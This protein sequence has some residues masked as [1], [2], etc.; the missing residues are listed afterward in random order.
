MN[1]TIAFSLLV[2]ALLAGCSGKSTNATD[3]GAQLPPVAASQGCQPL[4]ASGDA[5]VDCLLPYPSDFFRVADATLPS[6]FRLDTSNAGPVTKKPL[7]TD[8]NLYFHID[9][10]SEIPSIVTMFPEAVSKTGFVGLLDDPSL[11]TQPS[12]NVLF[13]EAATG[14]LIP[15]FVDLDPHASDP[16]RQAIVIHALVPLTPGGRYVIAVHGVKHPDGSL[17]STPL[18]F[19]RLRDGTGSEDSV[20]APLQKHFTNDVLPVAVKAGIAQSDLQM[21]WD[22]TVGSDERRNG[23]MLQVRKLVLQWLQSNTPTVSIDSVTTINLPSD[24]WMQIEGTVHGA[25]LYLQNPNPEAQLFRDGNGVVA[26]NGTTDFPFTV[27]VPASVRDNGTPGM[28]MAYGHGFFGSREEITYDSTRKVAQDLGAVMFAIDWWGMDLA[29]GS[30]LAGNLVDH[31]AKTLDFADRVHQ[32]MAN[33][34][35][36]TS[37]IRGQLC[38]EPQ[39]QFPLTDGG[40]SGTCIIDDSQVVYFGISQGH[41]LGGTMTALNPDFHKIILQ[42]GGV[43]FT[44]MM[45]RAKP[46]GDDFLPFLDLSMPDP[47]EQQKYMAM[48]Q[49]QFD[50]FDPATYAPFVVHAPFPETPSDRRVMLQNG[51]G[52]DEVPNLGTFLDYRMLQVPLVTPAPAAPFGVQTVAAPY[53][54][55]AASLYD[56]DIDL[57]AQY[58]EAVNA[59]NE[60]N[61]HGTLRGVDAALQQMKKFYA[62]GTVDEF[63]DGGPCLEPCPAAPDSGL[64]RPNE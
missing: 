42:M 3:A 30:E 21:A 52:D 35:V 50:R 12:S 47:L 10:A 60:N 63:C 6:G 41:I 51:L 29:D 11:S 64:C 1:R 37:A 58:A 9:G 13:I 57:Q 56:F 19:A 48:M 61:V 4:L 16:T 5:G 20:L 24:T 38:A 33:W 53:A 18:G 49:P 28:A 22:F 31:P 25:P 23:D 27:Q 26:Q 39:L 46:F 40:A 8:V 55:S 44:H 32:G 62:D 14:N 17:V 43:G 36:M 2:A 7:N 34:I 59:V 45:T 54:G 15:H